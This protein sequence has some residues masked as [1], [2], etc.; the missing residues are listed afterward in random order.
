MLR[1]ERFEP[2]A[3][4]YRDRGGAGKG[5]F[6]GVRP[7][8][9]CSVSMG[10]LLCN[11]NTGKRETP[12]LVLHEFSWQVQIIMS[13]LAVMVASNC[14]TIRGTMSV[15]QEGLQRN[16]RGQDSLLGVSSGNR[17]WRQPPG[18]R[19]DSN[20]KR[21]TVDSI[22]NGSPNGLPRFADLRIAANSR[23]VNGSLTR[24]NHRG[25]RGIG[26]GDNSR[27]SGSSF[28]NQRH[29]DPQRIATPRNQRPSERS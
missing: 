10:L 24:C 15:S 4:R 6:A 11:R 29:S 27:G 2:S 17:T 12:C 9:R 22:H 20:P 8:V 13:S 26:Q 1:V 28:S 18:R 21:F 25:R 14:S 23:S 3:G 7:C 16:Q 19:V 5:G